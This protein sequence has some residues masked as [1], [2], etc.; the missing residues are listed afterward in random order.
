MAATP[1]LPATPRMKSLLI[2]A[3]VLVSECATSSGTDRWRTIMTPTFFLNGRR[4]EGPWDENTLADALLGTLGH[5]VQAAALSFARWA[6]SAGLLLLLMSVLAVVLANSA[7]GPAFA[8]LWT[9]VGGVQMG[10]NALLL[11]ILKWINDGL[12]AVF[13]LVV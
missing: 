12:L 13:F 1:A 11:P 5:R 4:Y 2:C 9:K 7:L 10:E 8:S 6:P 3:I